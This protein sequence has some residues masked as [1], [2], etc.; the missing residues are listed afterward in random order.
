MNK[1]FQCKIVTIFLPI[2]LPF[3]DGAQKNHLIEM[4]PLVE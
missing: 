4:I 2:F 1:N 3:V